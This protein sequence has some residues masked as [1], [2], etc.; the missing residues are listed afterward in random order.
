MRPRKRGGRVW[1]VLAAGTLILTLVIL[2]YYIV[3]GV[4]PTS[5]L[6]LF[7]PLT[8]VVMAYLP[9]APATPTPNPT[10][11]ATPNRA[12]ATA[13]PTKTETPDATATV[14]FTFT[15]G[16][17]LTPTITPSPT[18]SP[19]T[20][21][22][23]INYQVHPVLT[24][25]WTGVAGTAIDL[26]GKPARGYVV[27][28]TS[29]DG[30]AQRVTA[31]SSP[32]YGPGGWELRLGERQAAGTWRVQLYTASNLKKPVSDAYQIV[33][34]GTCAKNLAFVRFQQNH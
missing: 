21:T 6:N 3:I 33:L 2:A 8:P 16:P 30:A 34:L 13:S 12:T 22:A 27:Q 7:P 4:A 11:T 23:I 29:A 1:N 9:T 10:A 20:F 14:Q 18:R 24:C 15:P 31:G 26:K 17:T 19:F 5:P 28:V 32:D 25:D